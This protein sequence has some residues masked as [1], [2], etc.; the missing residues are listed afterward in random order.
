MPDNE[1]GRGSNE[2]PVFPPRPKSS[3]ISIS[4]IA[5]LRKAFEDSSLAKWV[6]LAGIGGFVEA[7]RLL[8]DIAR[9]VHAKGF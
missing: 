7:V 4:E 8:W 1:S 6:I 5:E 2:G 9:Y 3:K